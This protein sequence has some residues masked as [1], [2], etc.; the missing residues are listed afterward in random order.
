MKQID[1]NKDISYFNLPISYF[2]YFFS[3]KRIS[4]ISFHFS[5]EMRKIEI[6]YCFFYFITNNYNL[7]IL[8]E[9][10][11]SIIE[12]YFRKSIK[13]MN[14]FINFFILTIRISLM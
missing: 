6:F 3:H 12:E 10:E 2:L 7:L 14:F 9:K 13:Y 4:F 1:K 11:I 8:M 5:I